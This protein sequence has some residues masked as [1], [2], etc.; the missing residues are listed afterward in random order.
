MKIFTLAVLTVLTLIV[1]PPVRCESPDEIYS[2]AEH[3]KKDKMFEAAAQQYLKFA[4]ENPTDRRA[5]VSL[6]RA[7]ECLVESGGIE[8]AAT[9]LE[10]L[11]QTYPGDCD[12]CRIKLQL[13]RLY[14]KL[15]R[16]ES[17]DRLFTDVVVTMPDCPAVPDALLGKG[18]A[19][20][21]LQKFDA[22]REVL[23]SLVT[24]FV[25]SAAAPRAS[26]N[27]AFCLRRLG[28]DAEAL[29]TY[30]RICTQFPADPL[31]GFASLEAARMHAETGD[32]T[33][34]VEY[35]QNARRFDAKVFFVPASDE[36]AALL[37]ATGQ[38]ARA[39]VWYEEML[40]RPD[41][42]DP[43]P[44]HIKAISAAYHAG[45][46][47][48]V[49][50]IADDY[51]ARFPKTFSPQITYATA[52]AKKERGRYEELLPDLDALER[53][54]PGT[55]WALS[56]PRIRGEALLA[57]GRPLQAVGELRRFVS[58]SADSAA[59]VE[60][61]EK[62][63]A[64]QISALGDTA[65][66]LN[67]MIEMLEVQR[68]AIPSELLR[69]GNFFEGARRFLEA[70]LVYVDLINRFPLS[71]EAEAAE[72]RVRYLDQ[73]TVTDYAAAAAA[74]DRVA[75]EMATMDD[76][77]ALLRLVRARLE[78]LK[79]FDS[80]LELCQRVKNSA[81]NTAH[82][83]QI[84]FTEGL[85]RAGLARTAR[86]AG[87]VNTARDL[88]KETFKPWRELSEKHAQSPWAAEAQFQEVL[89]RFDVEGTLDTLAAQRVLSR[90]PDHQQSAA[91]L[92][93]LGDYYAGPGGSNQR[94][95]S[96][97]KQAL[98][99]KGGDRDNRLNY[100]T[101]LAVAAGGKYKDA[102]ETF[103][104]VSESDKGRL[105]LQAAYEA[106]RALR[107]LE[108][109]GDAESYF[110]R[111][112]R[113]DPNGAFGANA[114][115]QAADCRYLRK[116]Y[117]GALA[118][119]LRAE[120]TARDKSRRA[121]ISYR[122]A[123]CL[124]QLGRDQEALA[125][126]ENGL[127]G[128]LGA[129]LRERAFRY[130]ADL[131]HKLGE[132][133]REQKILETYVA[134]VKQ[135]DDVNAAARDLIRLYLRRNQAEQAQRLAENV[136]RTAGAD[137]YE[138]KA[139]LAMAY[140]RQGRQDRAGELARQVPP[141][142]PVSL[143]R[144][145]ALEAAKYHYEQ[146]SYRDAL[147]VLSPLVG[148]CS[149]PGVCEGLRYYNA[150]T[151]IGA[152]DLERGSAAAQSFF[153]DYPVSALGPELHLKMGNVLVRENRT[154]EALLHYDEAAGTAADSATAFTA[155]KNL[156]V[157]YQQ[158]KRWREAEQVWVRLLN[159]FP[160]SEYT[161]DAALNI[162]R[163]K[164]ETGDYS[165]AIEAYEKSLPLL[166]GEAKARAYYWMGTSYEQLGDYQSAV[167]E[168]LKVPFL[169]PGEGLWVVTAQLKAAEC[170]AKLDRKDAARDIYNKVIRQYGA[171][172][173]WGQ[174]AQK[175]ID[176]MDGA[177]RD[178]NSGGSQQ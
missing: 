88:M 46:Y 126:L 84:L 59:R 132:N 151:L 171:T 160:A 27:L 121:E 105:G 124:R 57:L 63:S 54:A 130:A 72:A 7:A 166:D 91:V 118:G 3:L 99:K 123:L 169:H 33:A 34:A 85:S 155:L 109:Y 17:A 141:T 148:D 156:G 76:W 125:R 80:A 162:A 153:R 79:D 167:V 90:F 89:L 2:F 94:A 30:Q 93:L 112:S 47:D 144:E 102:F 68:R 64:A 42:D 135:G 25:E 150:L 22:A 16:Y 20:I 77:D 138:A 48:S 15:E 146:K 95:E 98:R 81:K 8:N 87:R 60:T 56:A 50:R 44:V 142:A 133:E 18:E 122:I 159:R 55:E 74:M 117:Q 67:T 96:Y 12:L 106:G 62:I 10:S 61:L 9:V 174:Q 110:D 53:F 113:A 152:G 154:A 128:Q 92:E 41:L 168:Y 119:Y 5:P 165:G 173:N 71:D 13:G 120:K 176:E 6:E 140:Y 139:L 149:E 136:S 29:N 163:C 170:Y 137:D 36:G 145:M 147:A 164:M 157:S 143:S 45:N 14:Y 65:S 23:S 75:Y 31:A 86:D 83:P 35:Y 97:Y 127:A 178:T 78:V 172:S 73:Y 43:R 116:D 39:L 38:Y 177:A 11:V 51:A 134:E 129:P 32:T 49:R 58:L 69:V 26:Y 158:L 66:A 70:K 40:A 1:S 104:D 21:S 107:Q 108:R 28:R 52:L 19:L 100:K 131:A 82:Y 101:A 161:R 103:R 111:V 115:L 24:N 114:A 37:E 4:R 175:G